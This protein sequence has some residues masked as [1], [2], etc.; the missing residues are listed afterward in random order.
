M[1]SYASF[2]LE[3]ANCVIPNAKWATETSLCLYVFWLAN[4]KASAAQ[5]YKGSS[6]SVKAAVK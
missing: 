5:D 1:L 6:P 2:V 4:K 3:S